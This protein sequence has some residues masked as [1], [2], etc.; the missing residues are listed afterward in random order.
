MSLIVRSV[1]EYAGNFLMKHVID[2]FLE[3][4]FKNFTH[5]TLLITHYLSLQPH[6]SYLPSC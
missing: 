2:F 3:S 4:G 5:Y 1:F 6:F